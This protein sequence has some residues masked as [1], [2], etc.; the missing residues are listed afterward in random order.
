[1]T[2]FI[3][4]FHMVSGRRSQA[5]VAAILSIFLVVGSQGIATRVG[6]EAFF[7]LIIVVSLVLSVLYIRAVK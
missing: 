2:A 3:W 6:I 5:R 4:R 7:A 1:L